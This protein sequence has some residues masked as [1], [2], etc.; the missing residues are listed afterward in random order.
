MTMWLNSMTR[1]PASGNFC[2]DALSAEML[3]IV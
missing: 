2:G 1:T 3:D